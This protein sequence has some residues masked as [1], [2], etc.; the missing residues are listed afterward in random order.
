VAQYG[1]IAATS[2][3]GVNKS[4]T[5]SFFSFNEAKTK[6]IHQQLR[7]LSSLQVPV[8]FGV[9]PPKS[10]KNI[11]ISITHRLDSPD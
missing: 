3:P 11:L 7:K 9:T 4:P 6:G 10:Q 2:Q 5:I 8:I 1:L